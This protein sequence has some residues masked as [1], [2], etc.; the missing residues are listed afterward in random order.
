[1]TFTL[2]YCHACGCTDDTACAGGCYWVSTA[3]CSTC[4]D[5]KLRRALTPTEAEGLLELYLL[6]STPA[7]GAATRKV[8]ADHVLAG[9]M[10]IRRYK[11]NFV[12]RITNKGHRYLAAAI[13]PAP[14]KRANGGAHAVRISPN[15]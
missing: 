14:S 5:R 10:I 9:R 1:M 8:C 7:L 15:S 11:G 3:R 13:L 4:R 2:R 6:S 12:L